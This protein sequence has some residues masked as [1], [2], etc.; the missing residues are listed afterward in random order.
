MEYLDLV[1]SHKLTIDYISKNYP[2][3]TVIFTDSPIT[4]DLSQPFLHYTD[5]PFLNI[6]RVEDT[7]IDINSIQLVVISQQS[8]F[9]YE[10]K[11]K[12][13]QMNLSLIKEYNISGKI[14]GIYK[15]NM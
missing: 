5:R 2:L 6:T 1:R 13:A 11:E 9:F 14:T 4:D 15:N 12:T 8:T 7:N 10:F 3:D